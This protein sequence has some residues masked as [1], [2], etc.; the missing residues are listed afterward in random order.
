MSEF[1]KMQAL[2]AE[3]QK[4]RVGNEANAVKIMVTADNIYDELRLIRA[5]LQ[6]FAAGR[7]SS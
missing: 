2:I 3:H 1:E 5:L 4:R 6:D 7:H